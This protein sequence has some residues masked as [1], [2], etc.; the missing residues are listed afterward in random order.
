MTEEE[1]Y[2]RFLFSD[3]LR[4]FAETDLN[5]NK[6]HADDVW[7]TSRREVVSMTRED[8]IG[9]TTGSSTA[10]DESSSLLSG[11]GANVVETRKQSET[12]RNIVKYLQVITTVVYLCDR[13]C[14]GSQCGLR[15]LSL[16]KK[17]GE[18]NNMKGAGTSWLRL[19][20]DS[21]RMNKIKINKY[22]VN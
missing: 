21:I 14:I 2:H 16:V 10:S 9:D 5:D 6:R 13:R 19:S 4:C 8:S 11:A 20:D 18:I 22:V 17:C 12:V 3:L 1:D 15:I 7:V